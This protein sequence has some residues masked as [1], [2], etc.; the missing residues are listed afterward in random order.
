M[1]D[2]IDKVTQ[3][4]EKLED[5]NERAGLYIV[6]YIACRMLLHAYYSV[7]Y[8]ISMMYLFIQCL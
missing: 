8:E 2:N 6:Q 4:G 5:I 7:F 1:I 3:R